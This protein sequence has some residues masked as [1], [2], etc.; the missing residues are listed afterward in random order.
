MALSQSWARSLEC[1]DRPGPA[2][3]EHSLNA[4]EEEATALQ[5]WGE[6]KPSTAM[7]WLRRDLAEHCND[8]D[9]NPSVHGEEQAPSP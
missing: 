2:D 5:R 9:A 8:Y 4:L 7:S 3:A 1:S 6:Q